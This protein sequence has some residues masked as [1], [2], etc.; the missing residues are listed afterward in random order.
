MNKLLHCLL[1]SSAKARR[2][3]GQRERRLHLLLLTVLLLGAVGRVQAQQLNSLADIPRPIIR[4]VHDT[5]DPAQDSVFRLGS[6]ITLEVSGL[7]RWIMVQRLM[8]ERQGFTPEQARTKARDLVLYIDDTPLVGLDMVALYADETFGKE[9]RKSARMTVIPS[10]QSTPQAE[11]EPLE[12]EARLNHLAHDTM[13]TAELDSTADHA[14]Q[15]PTLADDPNVLQ[16]LADNPVGVPDKVMFRLNRD[17]DNIKYWNVMYQTPWEAAHVG[18]IGLGYADR[19][20]TELYPSNSLNIKLELVRPSSLWVAVL[21]TV[22]LAVGMLTLALRSWLL[23]KTDNRK[24]ADGRPNTSVAVANPPYS[25]PKI[26]LAWWTFIIMS[27]FLIIYCVTGE[28]CEISSTTLALLGI[29][30][31]TT[32]VSGLLGDSGP[33][34]K[35]TTGDPDSGSVEVSRGWLTDI[36]SDEHGVSMSRLQQIVITVIMGYFFVRSVYETVA[37]P[38]WTPN[39]T[40][41]L[42]VSSAAYLGLQ[43]VGKSGNEP[44]PAEA[45]ATWAA[46]VAAGSPPPYDRMAPAM[47]YPASAPAPEYVPSVMGAVP[48]PNPAAAAA[49]A[50]PSYAPLP[51]APRIPDEDEEQ[52]GATPLAYSGNDEVQHR[53][54]DD[55]GPD[56]LTAP[57][58]P[59]RPLP[60]VASTSSTAW[61]GDY[62][63]G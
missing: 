16:L 34:S 25:L 43:R 2:W 18:K 28:M 17:V 32:A 8:L 27:S 51:Y 6:T 3:A 62:I 38:V 9:E 35:S 56:S 19:V 42:A 29:S 39:Q 15:T 5:A 47:A 52:P 49:P 61:G 11:P 36:L 44:S 63:P 7:N 58:P 37:M 22:L 12:L 40:L 1:P 60:T 10:V 23:R 41:L 31:G 24:G 4:H 21:G 46:P 55:M 53:D 59:A 48:A 13:T 54:E 14:R 30:A 57:A 26:Q 20:F 33:T 50:A 45:T